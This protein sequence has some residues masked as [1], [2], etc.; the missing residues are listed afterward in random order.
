MD[1]KVSAETSKC[2]GLEPALI[3]WP[4]EMLVA[5]GKADSEC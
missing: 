3:Y 2:F 4:S 5:Q 1:C